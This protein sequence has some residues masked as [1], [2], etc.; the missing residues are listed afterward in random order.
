MNCPE[1]EELAVSPLPQLGGQFAE[2]RRAQLL[3]LVD[4]GC[5]NCAV[6]LDNHAIETGS[7]EVPGTWPVLWADLC[8]IRN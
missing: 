5:G 4:I 1:G 8:A 2:G 6:C 7:A 3:L